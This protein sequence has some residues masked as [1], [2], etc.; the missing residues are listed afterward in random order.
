MKGVHILV[1]T[2]KFNHLYF[3]KERKKKQS[4]I[5]INLAIVMSATV[6]RIKTLRQIHI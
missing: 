5:L 6:Y 3:F 2:Y 1:A 4:F